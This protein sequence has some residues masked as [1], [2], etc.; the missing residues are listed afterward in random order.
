MNYIN[1]AAK[2]IKNGGLVAFPT[3]TVY[4]LGANA[5]NGDACHMIFD[6]K[7][8]PSNNPLIVHVDSLKHAKKFAE[9]NEEA[10]RLTE[11]WP[12]PLTMVLNRRQDTKLAD[13]VTAG[14]K[15]V[16]IR[17]PSDQT[18]LELIK[19]S[20]CSIAASSANKS[21]T[22]SAT[23]CYHVAKNFGNMVF[24]LKSTNKK[25]CGLESTII[26]LST[27]IPT[28]LRYGFITPSAIEKLLGKKVFIASKNSKIKA[29]GM[30]HKHY[31]PK[32]PLRLN[33]SELLEEEV[34]LNF[35]DS[36][37]DSSFSLNLSRNGDLAEVATN[38]FEY[39]HC[40]DEFCISNYLKAIAVAP[41]P[42]ISIGLAI[43]DRLS[44]ATD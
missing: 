35:A 7:N 29:P 4:G 39:L 14:L 28:I 42:N 12:G 24:I 5:C 17:I 13:Y 8:R 26:D 43:N 10:L 31:A 3:E 20:G 19:S 34:G 15:T 38:L 9:F 2:I 25:C 30:L 40:L 6:A 11:F 44:K 21:G 1:H 33:I 27:S 16:A 41:I 18:A 23:T 22:L 37:L 36:K 32:T